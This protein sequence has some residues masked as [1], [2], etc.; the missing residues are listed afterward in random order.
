[1]KTIVVYYSMSGNTK[2]VA[3]LIKKELKCDTLE[4]KPVK[5]YPSKGFK[6]FFWGGKSSVMKES[7]NLEE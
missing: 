3:D 6:K 2:Y 7:P 4:L 5:E 1:M